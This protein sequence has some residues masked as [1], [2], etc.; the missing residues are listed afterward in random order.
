M[1]AY[2]VCL[3]ASEAWFPQGEDDPQITVQKLGVTEAQYWKASSSKLVFG[4]KYLAAVAG[5]KVDV[6]ESGKVKAE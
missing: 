3:A 4:I 1:S 5:G 6:G 2:R